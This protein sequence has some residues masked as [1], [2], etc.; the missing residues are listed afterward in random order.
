MC[1][2][3]DIVHGDVQN[4]QP[5]T[6]GKAYSSLQGAKGG[7]KNSGPRPG[8]WQWVLGHH[9][10]PHLEPSCPLLLP[11]V[12]RT[13][14]GT[15]KQRGREAREAVRPANRPWATPC[16]EGKG[17]LSTPTKAPREHLSKVTKPVAIGSRLP[18][19]K[20]RQALQGTSEGDT[21]LPGDHQLTQWSV[22][23]RIS[24]RG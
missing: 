3:P 23:A 19:L 13:T 21:S 7:P 17:C 1:Y 8:P 16:L 6:A 14:V 22:Q 5:L 12:E 11:L 4:P 15:Q 2:I 18:Q 9:S 10:S 20:L 24:G